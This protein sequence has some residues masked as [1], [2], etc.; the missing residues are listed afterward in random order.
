MHALSLWPL[1][2]WPLAALALVFTGCASGPRASMP[3]LVQRATFD[4]G[5]PAQHI[6]LY[7]IDQRSKAV[8]GCGRRL[9]YV[10]D[11]LDRGME[12][13]CTW[14]ND[15]ASLAQQSW[16]QSY[17]PQVAET[18]QAPPPARSIR[19]ELFPP[20]YTPAPAGDPL[21]APSDTPPQRLFRTDLEDDS[22]EPTNP[23]SRTPRRVRTRLYDELVPDEIFERRR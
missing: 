14:R 8:L 19:T 9:I 17:H 20:G 13:D 5:C 23:E 2:R 22:A 18:Q 4:L 6:A 16:P 7:H 21:A 1:G 10:E 15:T 11:C 12:R 3:A